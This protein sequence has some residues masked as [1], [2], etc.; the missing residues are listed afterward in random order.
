MLGTPPDELPKIQC[1]GLAG[2]ASVPRHGLVPQ[3]NASWRKVVE[4]HC[5]SRVLH[6][7]DDSERFGT[8]V[9]LDGPGHAFGQPDTLLCGAGVEWRVTDVVGPAVDDL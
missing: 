1:V 9:L 8:G 5:P 7:T 3:I 2:Q 4:A 6:T